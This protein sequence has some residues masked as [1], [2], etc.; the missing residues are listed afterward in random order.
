MFFLTCLCVYVNKKYV[1]F[2]NRCVSRNHVQY[3]LRYEFTVL[4]FLTSKIIS[5]FKRRFHV[6]LKSF[7]PHEVYKHKKSFCCVV[8]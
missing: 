6:F 7:I 2:Y 4:I 8:L 3:F 1:H 5:T